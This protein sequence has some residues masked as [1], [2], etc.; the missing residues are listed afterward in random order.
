MI[1]T[2]EGQPPKCTPAEQPCELL[3]LLADSIGGAAQATAPGSAETVPCLNRGCEASWGPSE[4]SANQAPDP[5][6]GGVQADD[7][8]HVR[9]IAAAVA[10]EQ[11]FAAGC[12]FVRPDRSRRSD[13]L[14]AQLM[15]KDRD[16]CLEAG[17]V[18]YAAE[19][20]QKRELLDAIAAAVRPFQPS[21]GQ[22]RDRES[23]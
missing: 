11:P 1:S 18:G 20:E 23:L 13:R 9:K 10:E 21:G 17:L 4:A 8:E 19:P 3:R 5:R 2:A 15:K 14:R 12:R 22:S 16:R 6:L 7:R